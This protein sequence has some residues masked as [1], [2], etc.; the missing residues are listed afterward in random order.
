MCPLQVPVGPVHA[1]CRS[2]LDPVARFIAALF[3]IQS[4]ESVAVVTHL[5]GQLESFNLWCHMTASVEDFD[6]TRLFTDRL[7]S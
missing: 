5:I 6:L 2:P 3:P 1:R 7:Y 4:I